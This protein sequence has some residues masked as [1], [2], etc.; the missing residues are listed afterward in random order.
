MPRPSARAQAPITQAASYICVDCGYIYDESTPFAKLPNNYK[1]PV[2]SA[3]KRRFKSY[4]GSGRNDPK[5]MKS[6]MTELKTGGG[7]S[8]SSTS[9]SDTSGVAVIVGAGA[10]VLAA[11]YFVL[12]GYFS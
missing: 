1:C 2:C 4:A 9:G 3:P 12:N 11:V 7:D 8:S 10:V 6:R 5:S